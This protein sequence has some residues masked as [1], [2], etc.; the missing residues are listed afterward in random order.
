[1]LTVVPRLVLGARGNWTN[2]TITVTPG[3][4][5]NVLTGA[6]VTAGRVDLMDLWRDFPVAL[7][8]RTAS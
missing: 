6:L 2:T 4:W 7:L 8:E 5:H 3:T 1:V